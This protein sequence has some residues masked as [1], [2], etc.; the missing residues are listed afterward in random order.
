MSWLYLIIPLLILLAYFAVQ[1]GKRMDNTEEFSHKNFLI[2]IAHPDDEA[3]F[4]TPTISRLNQEYLN[5]EITLVCFSTGNADGLGKVRTKELQESC[6]F[7]GI[8]Q[9]EVIHDETLF[10]DSM[11]VEWNEDKISNK[12]KEVVTQI[13]PETDIILTFDQ[14]GISSHP[15]HISLYHGVKNFLR[16]KGKY[17]KVSKAY[18]LK[19]L[20]LWVKFTS[21]FG[22]FS[23]N[24]TEDG[25]QLFAFN[26]DPK[27]AI[28]SLS[29]HY[30][31][32]VWFRKL[33]TLFS[34]YVYFNDWKLVK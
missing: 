19:T 33:F 4:M 10:E 1:K 21:V 8:N 5:N 34:T 32:F 22:I 12:L 30:S 29:V 6:K 17:C 25:R 27:Y 14:Y 20:S 15:N 7:L 3:M 9:S 11:K 16:I 28:T 13:F 2:V 24:T 26:P 18:S 31:Q 23:R